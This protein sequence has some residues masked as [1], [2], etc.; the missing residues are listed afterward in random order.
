L[1]RPS[2]DPAKEDS[3]LSSRPTDP[4]PSENKLEKAYILLGAFVV[5]CL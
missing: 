5:S 2:P 4:P 1:L 3:D